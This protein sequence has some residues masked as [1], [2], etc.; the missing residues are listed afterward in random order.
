M[1]G[2]IDWMFEHPLITLVTIA[3]IA[4]TATVIIRGLIS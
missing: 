3:A 2:V 4:A 1:S